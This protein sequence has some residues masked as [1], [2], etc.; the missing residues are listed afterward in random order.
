MTNVLLK[1]HMTNGA[2]HR[3]RVWVRGGWG[4]GGCTLDKRQDAVKCII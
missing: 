4:V 2:M 1:K 3:M